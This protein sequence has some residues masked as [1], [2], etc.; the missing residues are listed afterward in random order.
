MNRTNVL[1][2]RTSFASIIVTSK[3]LV[4]GKDR[5][6]LVG[7]LA[8]LAGDEIWVSEQGVMNGRAEFPRK[9]KNQEPR[10]L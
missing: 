1:L 6:T 7:Q 9:W 5:N 3:R 8:R 10:D 4:F 2:I